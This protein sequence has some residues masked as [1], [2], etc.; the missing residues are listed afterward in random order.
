MIFVPAVAQLP[1]HC[2]DPSVDDACERAHLRCRVDHEAAGLKPVLRCSVSVH[3]AE[4]RMLANGALQ[5]LIESRQIVE[6][7]RHLD[8]PRDDQV[9]LAE[10][11]LGL[12]R[13]AHIT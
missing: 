7:S 11:L 4:R 8:R 6:A 10:Q 2:P 1:K 5:G 13:T 12:L 3:M 9:V